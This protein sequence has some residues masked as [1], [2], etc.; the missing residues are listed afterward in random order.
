MEKDFE[1]NGYTF[2]PIGKKNMYF[3]EACRRISSDRDLG[4]STYSWSK[5]EKYN[6]DEFYK[7]SG[8]SQSDLFLC[9]ENGKVY[10][11]GNNELFLFEN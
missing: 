5:G 2:R 11:P 8:N 4:I 7:A 6:Y 3:E 10:I 1:Y 9:L